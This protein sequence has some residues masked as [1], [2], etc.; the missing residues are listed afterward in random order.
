MIEPWYVTQR[1]LEVRI[2]T[3][4][5]SQTLACLPALL[6]SHRGEAPQAYQHYVSG[7]TLVP[8]QIGPPVNLAHLFLKA[9]LM[10]SLLLWRPARRIRTGYIRPR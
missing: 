6:F 5:H 10:L 2:F 4:T 3:S 8:M 9:T 7:G 1:L